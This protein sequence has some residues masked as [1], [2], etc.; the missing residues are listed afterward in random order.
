MTLDQ[1]AAMIPANGQVKVSQLR[2]NQPPAGGLSERELERRAQSAA[3]WVRGYMHC[4]ADQGKLTEA[5]FALLW[6]EIETTLYPEE[7]EECGAPTSPIEHRLCSVCEDG[8]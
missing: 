5:Q 4:L 1:L 2:R 8:E 6:R 3:D 7:C